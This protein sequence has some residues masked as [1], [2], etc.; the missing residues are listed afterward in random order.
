MKHFGSLSAI[1]RAEVTQLQSVN[2]AGDAAVSAIKIAEA[3]GL[4][5][6]HARVKG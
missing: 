1:L 2:G 4:H 3:V 6:N 5:I